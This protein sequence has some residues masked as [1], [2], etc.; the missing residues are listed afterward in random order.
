[1]HLMFDCCFN[2]ENISLGT[3]I[4]FHRSELGESDME[5][6]IGAQSRKGRRVS[7]RTCLFLKS[8]GIHLNIWFYGNY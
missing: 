3:F 5:S 2:V 4:F 1:M 6:E 8:L 7:L